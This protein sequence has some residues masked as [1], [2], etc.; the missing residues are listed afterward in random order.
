MGRLVNVLDLRIPWFIPRVTVLVIVSLG[1]SV[2]SD[3]CSITLP[4]PTSPCPISHRPNPLHRPTSLSRPE[5]EELGEQGP[6]G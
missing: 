2:A 3:G 6:L 4:D 1:V 5:A